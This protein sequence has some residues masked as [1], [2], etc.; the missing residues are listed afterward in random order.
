MSGFLPIAAEEIA[1]RGWEQLDFL[2]ISGD[3]Y[4]DHP[5]FG[6]AV[7]CRV[8]EAHG[9]KIALL[10]QPEWDDCHKLSVLGKPR[11]GVMISGGNLDSMLC[12]YTASKHARSV[13]KYTAG[14]VIGKRPDHAT[15]VYAK[16]AKQ[17]WPELPVIIGGIEASLRRFIHYDYWENRLLPS[18]L[19]DSGADLLVY[20]MGEQQVVEVADYLS[21]GASL[22]DMRYIRGTAYASVDKPEDDC[23]ELPSWREIKHD[24]KKFAEAYRLQSKEQDPFYGKTV[25]QRG[26]AKYIIQNPPTYP[27]TQEEMD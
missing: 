4:V 21:G 22:D 8:L 18:I 13:D 11:L 9:Y 15:V 16:L 26:H 10:C 24:K 27:M 14:G 20:G 3:A 5:S 12:H 2:F 7:I 19:E 17:L 6:P 23:V 25:I 1:E